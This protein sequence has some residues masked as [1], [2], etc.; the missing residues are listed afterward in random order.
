[1]RNPSERSG[2]TAGQ[3]RPVIVG[4]TIGLSRKTGLAQI[5]G[6]H[7]DAAYTI[8][9]SA[10]TGG[11]SPNGSVCV[12]GGG[13]KTHR[14]LFRQLYGYPIG[15]QLVRR[16]LFLYPRPPERAGFLP[17]RPD[18][19]PERKNAAPGAAAGGS[20]LAGTALRKNPEAHFGACRGAEPHM[21]P[22][23]AIDTLEKM[24]IMKYKTDC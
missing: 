6:G 14:Q 4:G 19:L 21:E 20:G 16:L 15:Q 2:V 10:G 17:A 13:S 18:F 3:A 22:L 5:S 23:T 12:T 24:C 11:S 1:M 7:S 9:A 8:P